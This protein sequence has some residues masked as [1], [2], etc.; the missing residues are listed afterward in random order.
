MLF[1]SGVYVLEEGNNEWA[2]LNNPSGVSLIVE[3]QATQHQMRTFISRGLFGAP[4]IMP[5]HYVTLLLRS[6]EC[7]ATKGS[8]YSGD[9]PFLLSAF[10]ELLSP[11]QFAFVSFGPTANWLQHLLL[12][13]Q[14]LFSGEPLF[15][16]FF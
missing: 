13:S 12:K 2:I 14:N 9:Q 10:P 7:W 11:I 1:L 8:L 5:H 3:L 6:S 15:F 4:P 16:F